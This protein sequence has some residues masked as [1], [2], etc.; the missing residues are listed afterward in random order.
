MRNI[1]QFTE[2]DAEKVLGR[3]ITDGE[4]RAL[5]K[6][7]AISLAE[8]FTEMVLEVLDKEDE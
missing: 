4:Y 3:P 5:V 8:A 2:A 1:A 6:V 7:A